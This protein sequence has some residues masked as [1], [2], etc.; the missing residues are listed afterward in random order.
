MDTLFNIVEIQGGNEIWPFI[1]SVAILVI[2][3]MLLEMLWRYFNRTISN[4]FIRKKTNGSAFISADSFHRFASVLQ[5][6]Y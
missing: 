1:L 6:W 4:L 5:C 3:F 2:G